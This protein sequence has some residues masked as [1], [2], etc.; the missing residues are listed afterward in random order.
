[1]RPIVARTSVGASAGKKKG[2]SRMENMS[3]NL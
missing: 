2:R 1:M 3:E